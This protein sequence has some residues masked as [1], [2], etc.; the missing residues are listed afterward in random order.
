M[1]VKQGLELEWRE[2]S[3]RIPEMVVDRAGSFRADGI[4][5]ECL[6]DAED[7]QP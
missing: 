5:G 1:G 6:A 7:M 4:T 3:P 2:R